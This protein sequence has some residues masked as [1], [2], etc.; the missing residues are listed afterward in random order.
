MGARAV[1]AH[2]RFGIPS[3]KVAAQATQAAFLQ[4][5]YLFQVSPS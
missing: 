4:T 5:G 3:E 2:H 1:P